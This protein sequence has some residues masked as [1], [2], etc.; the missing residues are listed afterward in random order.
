MGGIVVRAD[1]VQGAF[2]RRYFHSDPHSMNDEIN[3]QIEKMGLI[4]LSEGDRFRVY[5]IG[6]VVSIV[7]GSQP[8]YLLASSRLSEN[9]RAFGEINDVK[10]ALAKLWD[11][12]CNKGD[13][14]DVVI[15]VIGTG[16]ARTSLSREDAIRLII[17]SYIASSAKKT[18]CDRLI[19]AVHPNDVDKFK[20]NVDELEVFLKYSCEFADFESGYSHGRYE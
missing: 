20:I 5:P 19:I 2:L 9:G 15:P 14:G 11:F 10:T 12:I 6:T 16:N 17:K 7:R 1:S 13:K 4:P 8:F 3:R 18:Y